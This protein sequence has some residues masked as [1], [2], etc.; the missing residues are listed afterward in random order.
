MSDVL[1]EVRLADST[2][3]SGEPITWGSGQQKLNRSRGNMSSI[4]WEDTVF[5]AKRRITSHGDGT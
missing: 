5:Y 4:Q 2:A 3:R 1:T